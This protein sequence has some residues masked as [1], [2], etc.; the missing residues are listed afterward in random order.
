[1]PRLCHISFFVEELRLPL[2]L[3]QESPERITAILETLSKSSF[4]E[5]NEFGLGNCSS[6]LNDSFLNILKTSH[7]AG[8][9]V[10]LQTAHS[11]W[12]ANHLVEEDE[13]ILP[14]S[15]RLPAQASASRKDEPP[16]DVFA[17]MGYYAFD[18]SSGLTK[19]SWK[20]IEASAFLAFRAAFEITRKDSDINALALCRP[21]GH[22][23]NTKMAGGYCYV[24]N[25][26]IAVDALRHFAGKGPTIPVAILDIDYHHGNGTQDHFYSD[27][28]VLYTSIH[29]E[30]E[31]PYYSG[32]ADEHGEGAGEGFNLNLPLAKDS[33][34]SQYLLE[35]STAIIRITQ[36]APEFLVISLG[37]DTYFKD[38]LG[39]FKIRTKDYWSIAH[40][41]RNE[42][43]LKNIPTVILLEGGYVIE[44]LGAN[45][46]AF[47]DG[48]E[49]RPAPKP[50]GEE[51]PDTI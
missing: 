10:H 35:L 32:F 28:T 8:Y 34:V 24:N 33:Y 4:H 40:T 46:E 38:P 18:M 12:V 1:M 9:L 6:D 48:W 51:S 31:Y 22:H 49:G 37:F 27:S 50:S 29:G 21:P 43:R 11:E 47:L 26:V 14:E 20:S 7:D 41:I 42:S 3:E 36:F 2:S 25:A 13:S 19:D 5:V 23:C 39:S 15:F 30:D 44:D 17:R 16:K 45:M